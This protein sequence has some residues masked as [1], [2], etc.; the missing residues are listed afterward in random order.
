MDPTEN[1]IEHIF[2]QYY[3]QLFIY[4]LHF[5]NKAGAAEDIVQD[6]FVGLWQRKDEVRNARSYLF[7]SVRNRCISF[8]RQPEMLSEAWPENGVEEDLERR[9]EVEAD[10]WEAIDALPER[11]RE[12]FLMSK[13]DGLKYEEIAYRLGISVNTVRNHI[14]RSLAT[15]REVLHRI[16]VF[17]FSFA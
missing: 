16:I 10:I 1:N 13:R 17:L 8:L 11:R 7:A 3:R 9:S 14:A 6:A 15:I 2:R 12:V 5:V 4:A